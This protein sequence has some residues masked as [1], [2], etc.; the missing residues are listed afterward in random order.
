VQRFLE[1]AAIIEGDVFHPIEP[2]VYPFISEQVAIDSIL[3]RYG[4]PGWA[5]QRSL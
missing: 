3:E 1:A 4:L 5:E 2:P